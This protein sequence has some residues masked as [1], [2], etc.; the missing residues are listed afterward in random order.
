VVFRGDLKITREYND[1][2]VSKEARNSA[3][4]SLRL[5]AM[6]AI[7]LHHYYRHGGLYDVSDTTF[8]FL[9]IIAGASWGKWGV[10]VFVLISGYFLC[11]ELS[12]SK[13]IVRVFRLYV[14]IWTTAILCL[15]FVFFY[16]GSTIESKD[17]LR[18]ILPVGYNLW[19]F[20]TAY[21]ILSIFMPFINILLSNLSKKQHLILVVIM[22]VIWSVT[23]ILPHSNY[24]YSINSS[25]FFMLYVIGAY[26]RK[27][28][29]PK[30]GIGWA[31]LCIFLLMLMSSSTVVMQLLSSQYPSLARDRFYLVAGPSP[32][33]IAAAVSAVLTALSMKPWHSSLVNRIAATSFGIYL[34]SDNYL[35]RKIVWEGIFHTKEQFHSEAIFI[36]MLFSVICVYVATTAM[37]YARQLTIQ[38]PAQGLIEI[39]YANVQKRLRK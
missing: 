6:F 29:V 15:A 17:I 23:N 33:T 1:C 13:L 26:I 32:L 7:V 24:A 28:C 8:S 3:V 20:A 34:F 16:P 4:E 27:Y 5:I 31:I 39:C 19:W 36:H 22:R 12:A 35:V 9:T 37:E 10:D 30:N 18:S 2:S 21:L 11:S 25:L 38:K 14:Q